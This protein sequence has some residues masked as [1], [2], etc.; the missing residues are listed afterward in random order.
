[1]NGYSP[2]QHRNDRKPIYLPARRNWSEHSSAM[3]KIPF[4]CEKFTREVMK[5]V[6]KSGLDI[7]TVVSPSA[8]L[9]KSFCKSRPWDVPLCQKPETCLICRDNGANS[10]QIRGAIYEISCSCGATYVGETLRILDARFQEHL[11]CWKNP[12]KK[13]YVHNA[14]S[15][16]LKNIPM[17]KRAE[18]QPS[19]K[20]LSMERSILRRKVTEAMIIAEK[21]P[22]LNG[23]EEMSSMELL[24]NRIV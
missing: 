21:K 5:H 23:K 10:C 19:I 17:E 4:I 7:R 13:S 11:R 24:F 15:R 16:H 9:R 14:M 2:V 1:M 18:H 22:T 20:I 12:E 6:K 8:S 3:L